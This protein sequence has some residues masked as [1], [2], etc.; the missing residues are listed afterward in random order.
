MTS[1][2][3][4]L[5]L[6]DLHLAQHF[7][8]RLYPQ[9]EEIE[10]IISDISQ[11]LNIKLPHYHN[12]QSMTYFMFPD[13]TAER[14]VA[15]SLLSNLLYYID[16]L[17]DRH[18]LHP[19]PET[20]DLPRH[21]K[22]VIEIFC[23]GDA[24]MPCQQHLLYDTA[25]ALHHHFL[26]L[27]NPTWFEHFVK[28]L[29]EHLMSTRPQ[30]MTEPE[31]Y[32]SAEEYFR[33]RELDGGIWTSINSIEFAANRF[34]PQKIHNHPHIHD[35][36]LLCGRIA[37]LTNDLF[38]YEK[39]VIDM[40]SQFNLLAVL[41]QSAGLTFEQAVHCAIES[42]NYDTAKF[43]EACDTVPD[44][45]TMDLNTDVQMYIQGLRDILSA[46]WYWQMATDRYRSPTSP[47]VELRCP[48]P[49]L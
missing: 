21:F 42:I 32:N 27:S 33:V 1:D 43:V 44:F 41:M 46:T 14:L 4:L 48:S 15:L 29:T 16:D 38:S 19:H 18:K 45:G 39:E 5:C 26:Q 10:T 24:A 13:T 49:L 20:L 17:Y 40:G 3:D 8:L 11:T 22:K 35:M 37:T 28:V 36:S 9:F 7:P 34:L 31:H 2:N 25:L 30:S 23:L 12:Y 47:F 6:S